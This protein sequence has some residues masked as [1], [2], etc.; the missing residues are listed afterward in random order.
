[1]Y[2][3]IPL[4]PLCASLVTLLSGRWLGGAG[5]ARLTTASLFLTFA[6]S[7]VAFY[8]VALCHSPVLLRISP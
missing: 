1:M 4:L 6:L 7:C 5:A 8:E 2:L 3:L